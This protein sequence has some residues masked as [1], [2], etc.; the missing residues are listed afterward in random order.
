MGESLDADAPRL[1]DA[2]EVVAREVDE[3]HVLSALLR[4][5]DEL[6]LERAVLGRRRAARTRPG[7][8][9]DRS[10]SA[11]EPHE[12]LGRGADERLFA[13]TQEEVVRRG[14]HDPERA[15][16]GEPREVRLR[17]ELL[18]RD[19][20]DHLARAYRL[21]AARDDSAELLLRHLGAELPEERRGGCAALLHVA[22]DRLGGE[23]ALGERGDLRHRGVVLPFGRDPRDRHRAPHGVEHE[24]RLDLDE[25]G[26]RSALLVAAR[27]ARLEVG[28]RL[29]R[30]VSDL[31]AL[32]RR[33]L[34]RA[35]EPSAGARRIRRAESEIGVASLALPVVHALQQEHVSRR[36]GHARQ[37][38]DG[39]LA[40]REVFAEHRSARA[41]R[42]ATLELLLRKN[43][44]HFGFL[45]FCF[46]TSLYAKRPCFVRS[47]AA[48]QD[49]CNAR[50]HH[51]PR[52]RR[53]HQM[54][55]IYCFIR[56]RLYHFRPARFVSYDYEPRIF[57]IVG[58]YSRK[59]RFG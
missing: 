18:R 23:K 12:L 8:R 37:H 38:R 51:A 46:E 55:Q 56:W 17:D 31:P 15:V 28:Y 26:R 5:R 7:D 27:D 41:V 13:D 6:L 24:E 53:H 21:L 47:G 4:V 58:I 57:R 32:E 3:H 43:L 52:A 14:V 9:R 16:E 1:R 36:V 42:G 10:D 49:I 22:L 44:Q 39:R 48:R 25:R 35:D 45:L 33:K 40:V 11:L 34:R 20:L 54:L 19:D 50:R 2:A 59:L 30:E 29:V